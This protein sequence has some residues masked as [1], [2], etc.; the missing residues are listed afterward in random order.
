MSTDRLA[1]IISP[2]TNVCQ[3]DQLTKWCLGCG[4]SLDEI[5][6]W[7]GASPEWRDAVMATLDARRA[8][9]INAR[10]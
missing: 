7:A 5:A 10:R 3:I 9:L 2:C 8:Q 1:P 6:A 4:R